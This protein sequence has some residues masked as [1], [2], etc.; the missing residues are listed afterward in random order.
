MAEWY[1]SSFG[2]NLTELAGILTLALQGRKTGQDK[3]G[4]ALPAHGTPGLP[5][6]PTSLRQRECG[7]RI[8]TV[9]APCPPETQSIRQDTPGQKQLLSLPRGVSPAS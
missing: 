1:R 4:E 8:Q 3:V 7:L 2:P 9:G 5:L 6:C